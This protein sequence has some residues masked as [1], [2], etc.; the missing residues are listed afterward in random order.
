M[1]MNGC[2]YSLVFVFDQPE[3]RRLEVDVTRV[4]VSTYTILP[5]ATHGNCSSTEDFNV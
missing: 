3:I 5:L 1:D 2:A 4:P